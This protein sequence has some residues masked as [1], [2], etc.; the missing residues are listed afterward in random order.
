MK[1]YF[2]LTKHY[3]NC[4]RLGSPPDGEEA[5]YL[6]WRLLASPDHVE[7]S[8]TLRIRTR[9][10]DTKKRKVASNFATHC[11]SQVRS[12]NIYANKHSKTFDNVLMGRNVL[13]IEPEF[14]AWVRAYL[15]GVMNVAPGIINQKV[16]RHPSQPS[17]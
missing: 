3:C 17:Q 8:S 12:L 6:Y 1:T 16:L 11:I 15:I 2:N 14:V 10:R 4:K 13:P 9:A 7:T 5:A